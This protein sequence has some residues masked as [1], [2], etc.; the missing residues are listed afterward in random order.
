MYNYDIKM[1]REKI[2]ETNMSSS[3]KWKVSN[4]THPVQIISLSIRAPLWKNSHNKVDNLLTNKEVYQFQDA[5]VSYLNIKQN[6]VFM[7]QIDKCL[8][9]QFYWKTSAHMR[10]HLNR[11]VPVTLI[12]S[13]STRTG[14]HSFSRCWVLLSIVSLKDM[15]VLIICVFK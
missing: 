14:S 13:C 12:W 4:P 6:K 15:C 11:T 5:C 8:S 9:T 3:N 1:L 2:K 7:E 10:K